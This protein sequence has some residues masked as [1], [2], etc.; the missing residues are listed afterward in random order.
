MELI[1]T[2]TTIAA[3]FCNISTSSVSNGYCY[4]AETNGNE[5]NKITVFEASGKY[6]DRKLQYRFDYDALGRLANKEAQR[7]NNLTEQWENV[8]KLIYH[9][10]E[11]GFR[12][13]RHDWDKKTQSYGKA[14]TLID[15]EMLGNRL[16]AVTTYSW[17]TR[18]NDYTK[19]DGFVIMD[20]HEG[21]LLAESLSPILA[22]EQK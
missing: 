8:Y 21:L 4:N 19:V 10:T 15:Y 17:D 22:N 18:K 9:Y 11:I 20:P 7:W 16:M 14:T 3:M 2:S 12:L 5:V 6:L 1:I 13:S